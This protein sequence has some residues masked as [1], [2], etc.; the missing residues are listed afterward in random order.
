MS[1]L[2][3]LSTNVTGIDESVQQLVSSRA[4]SRLFQCDATLWGEAAAGLAQERLG[5]VSGLSS[6][7]EIVE[8]ANALRESLRG[9]SAPRVVLCGMGGSS[10]AAQVIADAHGVDLVAL[11]S[12]HPAD[13]DHAL[14]A[15]ALRRSVVVIAT[16]SGG[17]V[18]TRSMLALAQDRFHAIGI[19]PTARI[20]MITDPGTSLAQE[21]VDGGYRLVSADPTVGGRYSALTVFGLVAPILAGADLSSVEVEA[22]EAASVLA[23]DVPE[24]PAIIIAATLAALLQDHPVVNFTGSRHQRL[25]PAW[26]EQ[27]IAESTGKDGTGLLPIARGDHYP[28]AQLLAPIVEVTDPLD[29]AEQDERTE[30]ALRVRASMASQ[31]LLWECVTVFLSILLN[32]NPFDQPDVEATKV[33]TKRILDAGAELPESRLLSPTIEL[34]VSH[35]PAAFEGVQTLEQLT[36]GLTEL[37]AAARYVVVQAYCAESDPSTREALVHFA[38]HLE[39]RLERPVAVSYGPQYLHST[40]QLHKG[41]PGGALFLQLVDTPQED[42]EIPGTEM[43]FATLLSAAATADAEVLAGHGRSVVSLKLNDPALALCELVE[44]G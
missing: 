38:Q 1:D 3:A 31:F 19:D 29:H 16:K 42:I 15:H 8:A 10:L 2:I 4:A 5:W 7:G 27:L 32:V 11:D 37:S 12:T 22:R 33:A 21:A 30:V 6:I 25:M 9:E 41:S 24:N 36:L 26:I 39:A 35:A 17:T 14:S 18:E 20:I 44:L 43:T 34:L 40:G 28:P 23:E 13:V